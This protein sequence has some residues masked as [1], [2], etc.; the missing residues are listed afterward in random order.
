MG[1]LISASETQSWSPKRDRPE[2]NKD[3]GISSRKD[4]KWEF[5][6]D[7]VGT[8]SFGS[9]SSTVPGLALSY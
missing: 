5:E 4:P 6:K 7:F 1:A 9:D 8:H 2:C 3:F